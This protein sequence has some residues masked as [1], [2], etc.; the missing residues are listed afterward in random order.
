MNYLPGTFAIIAITI[1]MIA[2][3][4]LLLGICKTSA[5]AD[6]T[7][8]RLHAQRNTRRAHLT[9]E[10]RTLVAIARTQGWPVTDEEVDRLALTASTDTLAHTVAAYRKLVGK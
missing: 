2:L 8:R 9:H 4:L 10:L 1:V 3:T 7:A 5:Q 6:R